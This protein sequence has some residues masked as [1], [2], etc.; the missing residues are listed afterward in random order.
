MTTSA[1]A[2]AGE[3]V[4]EAPSLGLFVNRL[5]WTVG[6][7]ELTSYFAQFGPIAEARVSFDPS[8]GLSQGFG[9]VTFQYAHS[10]AEVLKKTNLTL[11]GR[12]LNISEAVRKCSDIC[13]E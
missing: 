4:R 11:E 13:M 2:F 1:E 10:H 12:L 7:Q 3:I 6:D 8:T 9:F 5:P